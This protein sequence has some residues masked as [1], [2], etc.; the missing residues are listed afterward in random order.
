MKGNIS[1]GNAIMELL[2]DILEGNIQHIRY[3]KLDYG[4]QRYSRILNLM[5]YL[6]TFS[7][8]QGS[9]HDQLPLHSVRELHAF[10]KWVVDFIGPINLNSNN[11]NAIYII[12]TIDYIMWWDEE[13]EVLDYSTD[14]TARFIF[15]NIIAQFGCPRILTSDQDNHFIS[16]T[17]TTLMT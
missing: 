10:E 16:R 4:G 7:N 14:T 12:T 8:E 13:K 5:L 15:E 2:E 1:F 11:S 9:H 6:M 3:F 17:I